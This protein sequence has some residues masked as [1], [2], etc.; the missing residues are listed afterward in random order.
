MKSSLRQETHWQTGVPLALRK[1]IEGKC[2]ETGK[3]MLSKKKQALT[4]ASR[5]EKEIGKTMAAYKCNHC[6]NWHITTVK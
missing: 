3:V 1:A 2:P 6:N 4:F 5:T